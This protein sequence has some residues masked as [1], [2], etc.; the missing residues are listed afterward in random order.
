LERGLTPGTWKD[1]AMATYEPEPVIHREEVRAI[2][3]ALGDRVV[4]LRKISRLLGGDD[5]ETE[6]EVD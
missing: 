5:E 3:F 6:A 2:L 1:P 4:E